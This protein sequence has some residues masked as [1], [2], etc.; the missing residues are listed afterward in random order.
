LR[1][2]PDGSSIYF[3]K[4]DDLDIIQIYAVSP[5]G[6]EIVVITKNDFSP[7]TTFCLSADGKYLAFGAKE[8]IYVTSVSNGET[9]L[10]LPAPTDLNSHLSNI[11]WSNSGYRIAYNRKVDLNGKSYYQIFTL[12]LSSILF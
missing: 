1:S 4:K 11:N 2:S 3:Y 12:D 8:A 6:G 9:I 7:D 5:N 10:V